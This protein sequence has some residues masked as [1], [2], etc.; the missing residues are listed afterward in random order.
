[1]FDGLAVRQAACQG[2]TCRIET[3]W[4]ALP[5][6]EW[7]TSDRVGL[8]WQRLLWAVLLRRREWRATAVLG[9]PENNGTRDCE[10]RPALTYPLLVIIVLVFLSGWLTKRISYLIFRQHPYVPGWVMFRP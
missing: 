3:S 5:A 2:A 6:V 7:A 10:A 9:K 1:M 8:P 4:Q